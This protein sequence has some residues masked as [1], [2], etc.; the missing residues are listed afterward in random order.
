MK[1]F[2][3]APLLVLTYGVFRLFDGMDGE[4]GPGIAWTLGH[5]A[6][7]LALGAFAVVFLAMRRML[8]RTP[9][10]TTSVAVGFVGL[11]CVA[12]QFGIDLVNGFVSA[13]HAAMAEMSLRVKAIP[14]MSLAIYDAGPYLF[15]VAQVALVIQLFLAGKVK[16]WT[17]ILV[18]ADVTMPVIS[19][20]LIPVGSVLLLVSFLPLARATA[21]AAR[22]T[23][24]RA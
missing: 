22:H 4:R 3:A 8:G 14:G 7:L 1:S 21:P 2:I 18:L 23:L 10:A 20:D 17:P 15:Y 12:A 9:L 5:L 6:F 16:V 11:A 24:V 19:K 13:D